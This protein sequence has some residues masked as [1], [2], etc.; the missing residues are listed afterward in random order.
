MAQ[1]RQRVGRRVTDSRGA[2]GTQPLAHPAHAPPTTS[3]VASGSTMQ[4][5]QNMP[6]R[7]GAPCALR[8]TR[9]HHLAR[10]QQPAAPLPP[11]RQAAPHQPAAQRQRS[12]HPPST[13]SSMASSPRPRCRRHASQLPTSQQPSASAAP[14]PPS[15]TSSMASSTRSRFSSTLFFSTALLR[16]G[17]GGTG[18]RRG[19]RDRGWEQRAGPGSPARSSPSPRCCGSGSMTCAGRAAGRQLRRWRQRCRPRCIAGTPVGL[20]PPPTPLPARRSPQQ[21]VDGLVKGLQHVVEHHLRGVHG[22]GSQW[23]ITRPAAARGSAPPAGGGW[24]PQG[25][26]RGPARPPRP[27]S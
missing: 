6:C 11:S 13:T 22:E 24:A 8:L 26:R 20:T 21:Q 1:C 16:C 23:S 15:T 9:L 7:F 25:Q 3:P 27:L 5:H 19:C 12:A 14:H 10:G 4:Q 18:R 2:G 17:R